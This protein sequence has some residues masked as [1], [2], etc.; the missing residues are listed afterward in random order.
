MAGDKH[1]NREIRDG[2]LFAFVS[3]LWILCLLPLFLK[4]DNKF[5]VFHGKQGLILFIGEIAISVIGIIPIIGWAVFFTGSFLI[6]VLSL[7]GMIQALSG[8]YW[9]MPI[10]GE[11]AESVKF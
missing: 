2:K 11:I 6:G 8:N 9:K 4:S 3:Y 5:A 1:E 10:V 7:V